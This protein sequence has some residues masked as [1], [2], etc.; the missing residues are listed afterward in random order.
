M[1]RLDIEE[2]R[3]ARDE[4]VMRATRQ[5]TRGSARAELNWDAATRWDNV[6]VRRLATQAEAA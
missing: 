6:L 2:L 5:D 4:R 1:K 3:K